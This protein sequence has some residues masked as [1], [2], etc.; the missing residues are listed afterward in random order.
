MG[1][2]CRCADI[3]RT[4]H[5]HTIYTH[6]HTHAYAQHVR[7]KEG[8]ARAPLWVGVDRDESLHAAQFV[9]TP[10]QELLRL[11]GFGMLIIVVVVVA[12]VA[13]A[14]RSQVIGKCLLQVQPRKDLCA[15]TLRVKQFVTK[16]NERAEGVFPRVLRCSS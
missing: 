12:V 11:R 1:S 15:K 5:I 8:P 16:V 10:P 9:E 6:I 7:P 14:P 3:Q 2:E 13:V 4:T